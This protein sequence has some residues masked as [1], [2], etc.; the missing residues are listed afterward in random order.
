MKEKASLAFKEGGGGG[1]CSWQMQ[2]VTLVSFIFF[3]TKY[4][5]PVPL[6]PKGKKK[7]I[8]NAVNGGL[9]SIMQILLDPQL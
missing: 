2:Y 3:L 9:L 8:S 7:D 1:A 5:F 6:Y 4:S